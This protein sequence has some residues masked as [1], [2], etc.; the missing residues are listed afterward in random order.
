M[1]CQVEKSYVFNLDETILYREIFYFF[2]ILYQIELDQ[3]K[4]ILTIPELLRF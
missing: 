4:S 1:I 3:E 2:H